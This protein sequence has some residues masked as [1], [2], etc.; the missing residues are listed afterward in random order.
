[1]ASA[2]EPLDRE[3]GVVEAPPFVPNQ[4]SHVIFDPP[5]EPVTLLRRYGELLREAQA[6]GVGVLA[7]RTSI[8]ADRIAL[9]ESLDILL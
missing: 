1:M 5:L 3:S 8:S 6:S 2:V 9:L 7:W 4:E